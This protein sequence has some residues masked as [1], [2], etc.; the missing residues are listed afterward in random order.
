MHFNPGVVGEGKAITDWRLWNSWSHTTLVPFHLDMEE[1]IKVAYDK[2][3]NKNNLAFEKN[4]CTN[5]DMSSWRVLDCE[6]FTRLS[7]VAS[8]IPHV[9]MTSDTRCFWILHDMTFDDMN[10]PHQHVDVKL[11]S[12]IEKMDSDMYQIKNMKDSTG[13][14]YFKNQLLS[15]MW[16]YLSFNRNPESHDWMPNL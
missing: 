7:F 10:I 1:T 11:I 6:P 13:K 16:W 8:H 5:P 4:P 3:Y 9:V 14:R 15:D 2:F 12:D